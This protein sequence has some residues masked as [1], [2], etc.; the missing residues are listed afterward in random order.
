MKNNFRKT[1]NKKG[2]TLIELLAVIVILAVIALI[3]TPRIMGAIEE[4]RMNS[5]K[6]SVYGI[7]KAAESLYASSLINEEE[8]QKNENILDQ[9]EYSGNK[10]DSGEVIITENSDVK[11]ALVFGEKCF[12][13]I[14]TEVEITDNIEECE[15]PIGD[16][17]EDENIAYIYDSSNAGENATPCLIEGSEFTHI[18]DKR[19]DETYK[20]TMIGEQCWF[21]ENLAYTDNGNLACLTNEWNDEAPFDS[22][23]THSTDWGTEVLYQWNAAM[24][25]ST[26]EGSQGLCPI[27]WNIPTDDE[28]TDLERAVCDYAENADCETTFPYGSG[29]ERGTN[30]SSK[31]KSENNWDGINAVG[32]NA[33]P[34]GDRSPTVELN[35]VGFY[36]LWW[37][38][39]IEP[40]DEWSSDAWRRYLEMNQD[41]S[42]YRQPNR[43]NAGYSVRCILNQ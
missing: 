33:L 24:D 7:V 30:E 39:T 41:A 21:A 12:L 11:A 37:T 4:A 16:L 38:S 15:I 2:F 25:G 32:F 6:N 40:T 43:K 10:P 28:W 31:L 23:D 42:V 13:K 8:I 17:P 1:E 18:L 5:N 29:T 9:I 3:A 26:E 19:D 14:G 35:G 20:V 34:A 22:C 27:G 36:A